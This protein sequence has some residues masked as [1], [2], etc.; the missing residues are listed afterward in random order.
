MKQN[1]L[2]T[3]SLTEDSSRPCLTRMLLTWGAFGFLT[4]IAWQMAGTTPAGRVAIWALAALAGTALAIKAWS[5][6]A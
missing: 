4:S 3:R 2:T 1:I 6:E 5:C